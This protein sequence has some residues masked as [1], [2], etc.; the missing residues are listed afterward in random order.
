[1]S[2]GPTMIYSCL[3]V[4]VCGSFEPLTDRSLRF[5]HVCVSAVIV[6]RHVVDGSI[7]VICYY[8]QTEGVSQLVVHVHGV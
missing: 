6:T 3:F 4:Q 1:M 2:C 5:T 7:V 8:H